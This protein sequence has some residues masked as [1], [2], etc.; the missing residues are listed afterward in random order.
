[1]NFDD[2]FMHIMKVI[3]FANSVLF[4]FKA[5]PAQKKEL[6]RVLLL[7]IQILPSKVV[8]LWE[9]YKASFYFDSIILT[10]TVCAMHIMLRLLKN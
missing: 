4:H 2:S 5:W 6:L 7:Q 10:F 8:M 1:M 3:A 9:N